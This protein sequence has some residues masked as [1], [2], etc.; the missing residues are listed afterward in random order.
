M[1]IVFGGEK[2]GTGKT[3]LSTNITAMLA[4]RGKEVLLIDTDKQESASSWA[5]TRTVLPRIPCILK[6]GSSVREEIQHL[7]T[8]YSNIVVD[9]GGR[10]S[11]EFRAALLVA[12]KA[13]IPMRPTQ[14]DL[15]TIGKVN[16]MLADVL[17]I[18]PTLKAFIVINASSTNPSV[19]ESSDAKEY[20]AEEFEHISVTNAVIKDRIAFHKAASDGKSVEEILPIDQKAV[21]E[22]KSLYEEI[23]NEI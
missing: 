21:A 8:K 14:F 2:G 23:F 6:F 1:V 22:L 12:D 10:D 19:T 18:N 15:W 9:C 11:T 7:K 13:I 17:Q 16:S 3:T 5:C 20:A 4:K